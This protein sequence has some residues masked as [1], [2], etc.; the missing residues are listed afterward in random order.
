M[1]QEG[2]GRA[3]SAIGDERIAQHENTLNVLKNTR[4]RGRG[5]RPQWYDPNDEGG[6]PEKD[7]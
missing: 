2:R 3:R 4:R 6:S 7:A 1:I 5:R